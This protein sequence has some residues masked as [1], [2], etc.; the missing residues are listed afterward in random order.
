VLISALIGAAIVLG[1]AL[2]VDPPV[3]ALCAFGGLIWCVAV[4]R[5]STTVHD[6]S[7]GRVTITRGLLIRRTTTLALSQVRSIERR[8]TLLDRITGHGEL[9]LTAD[10]PDHAVLRLRGLARRARLRV[11]H[12][13]LSDLIFLLRTNSPSPTPLAS[14]AVSR[15]AGHRVG[16]DLPTTKRPGA[17][18]PNTAPPGAEWLD[19]QRPAT[20]RAGGL[21]RRVAGG[22]LPL[23]A[24]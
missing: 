3:P 23:R 11:L 6:L 1:R 16:A 7:E 17:Q 13:I 2:A 10:A 22:Q 14:P 18:R 21:P 20:E 5:I 15:P 12:A 9:R 24:R 8:R 19:G 4:L